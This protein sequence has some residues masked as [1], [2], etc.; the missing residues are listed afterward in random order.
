MINLRIKRAYEPR[1]PDDG[2][3]VLVDGLWPRGL[4]KVDLADAVWL[5]EIAPSSSLRRWF[6]HKPERW[7]EFR[8]RYFAEL[9]WNP[10]VKA[11]TLIIAAGPTTLLF[12]ARD[13]VHNQAV[14]L[15]E[16]MRGSP[17]V[18]DGPPS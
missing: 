3:R 12:G 14:A 2:R 17:S 18:E 13:E 1:A 9:E 7:S 15:C 11:L 16:Y 6:G 10:A 4:T 8:L 5:R